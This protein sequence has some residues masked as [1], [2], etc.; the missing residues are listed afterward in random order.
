MSVEARLE[1]RLTLCPGLEARLGSDGVGELVAVV[2][3]R[4]LALPV[5]SA[6][7]AEARPAAAATPEHLAWL[8]GGGEGSLLEAVRQ[9]LVANGTPPVSETLH[10]AIPCGENGWWL[11]VAAY[12]DSYGDGSVEAWW[13]TCTGD[14]DYYG[15]ELRDVR[16]LLAAVKR[17]GARRYAPTLDEHD[18]PYGGLAPGTWARL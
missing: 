16:E 9:R 17:V 12:V 10:V 11:N 7:W 1:A 15:H 5:A 18:S 8:S 13:D 6:L 2:D 4:R 14:D 3:G